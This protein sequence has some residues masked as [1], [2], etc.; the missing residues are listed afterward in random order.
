M[1]ADTGIEPIQIQRWKY[2]RPG[3]W[4]TPLLG[5][6]FKD[7]KVAWDLYLAGLN[8]RA[9]GNS[10]WI[11]R[12]D[13]PSRAVQAMNATQPTIEHIGIREYSGARPPQVEIWQT[14]D[15]VVLS[16]LPETI[17]QQIRDD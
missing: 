16:T 13:S 1:L 6:A 15:T 10:L 7:S 12:F 11:A 8:R 14:S 9:F 5:A 3:V 2:F 17:N 4:D